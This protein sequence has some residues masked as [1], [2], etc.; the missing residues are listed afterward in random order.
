MEAELIS[1]EIEKLLGKPTRMCLFSDDEEYGAFRQSI[2]DAPPCIYDKTILPFSDIKNVHIQQDKENIS[3]VSGDV[4]NLLFET[5]INPLLTYVR[6]KNKD[7]EITN[8]IH[9]FKLNKEGI[10]K[11]CGYYDFSNNHFFIMKGSV[12]AKSFGKSFATSSSGAIRKRMIEESCT[13]MGNCYIVNN[14]FMCRTATSAASVLMGKV[15]HYTSWIDDNGRSLAD[16]FPTRFV[17]KN[18]KS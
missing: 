4:S 5:V 12:F 6:L 9:I 3:C 17:I 15:S 2:I 1:V 7:E 16:I 18:T 11:A 10:C 8:H 13:D 14:D